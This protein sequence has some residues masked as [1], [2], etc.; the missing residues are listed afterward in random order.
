MQ[1]AFAIGTVVVVALWVSYMA[2]H[3]IRYWHNLMEYT[4]TGQLGSIEEQ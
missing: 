2:L 1:R 3:A 4:R